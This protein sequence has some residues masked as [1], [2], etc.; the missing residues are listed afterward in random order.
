MKVK[1]IALDGVVRQNPTFRL[2]LGTCP[3]LALTTAAFNGIG[4]GLSVT[5]V[6]ICSNVL[7]S[8]LRKIIPDK[9]RIPAFVLIIATFVTIV[10]MVLKNL[11][12][13]CMIR[14]EFFCR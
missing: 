6:L 5:F 14:W 3:M 2:V 12:P 9:V 13:T 11:C 4:M 7:V 1:D 10:Q 8:L